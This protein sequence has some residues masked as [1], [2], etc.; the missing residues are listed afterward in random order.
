[1]YIL[2]I[3]VINAAIE[4]DGPFTLNL[5]PTEEID[6]FFGQMLDAKDESFSARQRHIQPPDSAGHMTAQRGEPVYSV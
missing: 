4:C 2:L 3:T 6:V 1:M 5:V